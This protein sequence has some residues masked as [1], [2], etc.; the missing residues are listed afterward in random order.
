MR[1]I[2]TKV[3]DAGGKLVLPG[4]TDCHVHFCEGSLAL[5]RVSLEGAKRRGGNSETP[6]RNTPRSIPGDA[7]ILGRGWNYAMFGEAAL[8]NKKY[9]DELFPNRPVFLEGYDGHTYWVNS[10][11]LALAGITK[12]TP[13]P[14]NGF[15]RPRS[16]NR[17]THRRA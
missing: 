11:A 5:G 6:A 7:W 16:E 17:R 13:D 12:S 9:L 15:D 2:G 8:P 1:G 14:A 3:I 4:F 10:K